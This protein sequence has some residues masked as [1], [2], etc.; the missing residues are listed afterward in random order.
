MWPRIVNA[1][2][3]VW[4]LA[5]PDALGYAGAQATNDRIVGPLVTSV[6]LIAIW[7]VTRALRWFN[8][9]LGV[10]LLLAPWF[11]RDG[12]MA[13]ANSLLCG[14]LL[15]AVALLPGPGGARVG[16]GWREVLRPTLDHAAANQPTGGATT[17]NNGG[18]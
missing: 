18:S 14:A 9:L 15:A 17:R 3:G 1:L 6:A 7:D 10:W 5:A 2:I 13:S 8:V 12:A 11:F 4:L 16:G